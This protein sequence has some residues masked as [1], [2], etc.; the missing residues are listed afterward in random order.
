MKK[1]GACLVEFEEEVKPGR[2]V[3][4]WLMKPGQL[5]ALGKRS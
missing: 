2:A 5:R 1:G 3:L 4:R